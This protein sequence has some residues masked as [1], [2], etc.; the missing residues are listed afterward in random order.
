[1]DTGVSFLEVK[2]QGRESDYPL[3]SS[4]EVKNGAALL[5]IRLHVVVIN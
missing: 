3:S 2:G 1:M 5:P 4:A